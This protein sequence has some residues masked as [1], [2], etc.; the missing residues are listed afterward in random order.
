MQ[1]KGSG[2]IV[3]PFKSIGIF[4]L[5][6]APP[7]LLL[8]MYQQS[9]KVVTPRISLIYATGLMGSKLDGK[10]SYCPQKSTA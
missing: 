5:C 8:T 7:F 2:K 6:L 9:L 10:L 4:R 3:R 1:A